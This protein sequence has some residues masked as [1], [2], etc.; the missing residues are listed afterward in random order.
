LTILFASFAALFGMFYLNGMPRPWRPV[1][2]AD[3]F[4]SASQ[5][6]FFL[7]I[8]SSDPLFDPGRTKGFLDR[9]GAKGVYEV[10]A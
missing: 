7:W 8:A 4:R 2:S 3:R 10:P 6:A 1:F 5:D 9:L